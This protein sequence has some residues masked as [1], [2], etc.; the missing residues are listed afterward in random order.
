MNIVLT[1][2]RNNN[3]YNYVM[4]IGKVKAVSEKPEADRKTVQISLGVQRPFKNAEGE[5]PVDVLEVFAFELLADIALERI[6]VGKAITIKGRLVP[7]GEFAI[8]VAERI[9]FAEEMA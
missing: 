8:I 3:M 9:M 4:L 1:N 5:F 2:R 6:E 7:H